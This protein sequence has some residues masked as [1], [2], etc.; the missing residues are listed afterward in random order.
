MKRLIFCFICVL[1]FPIFTVHYAKA[2]DWRLPFG[3]SYASA[4]SEVTDLRYDNLEVEEGYDTPNR[5]NWPVGFTLQPY[6]EFNNGL[7]IGMGF[8]PAIFSLTGKFSFT[9]IP[10]GADLRYTFYKTSE[11]SPY[12]RVGARYNIASGDYVEG[13][14]PGVFGAIGYEFSRKRTLGLGVELSYDASEIE[15]EKYTKI[16]FD[17]EG[18]FW[19]YDVG[20]TKLK[21]YGIMLSFYT[22]F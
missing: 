18:N 7:G 22:I 1:L 12:V 8:G 20:T 5:F 19:N 2:A 4:L 3:L 10:V 15:F 9:N 21:P 13:S 17:P 11:T 6:Y 16:N 14:Y